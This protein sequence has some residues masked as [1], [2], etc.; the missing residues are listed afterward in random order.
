MVLKN[1][2]A[3]SLPSGEHREVVVYEKMKPA[4]IELPRQAGRAQRSPLV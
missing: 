3:Y 2:R 1:H 4:Q